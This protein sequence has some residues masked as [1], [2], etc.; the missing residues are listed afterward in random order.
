MSAKTA[1]AR[2]WIGSSSIA[3]ILTLSP[4]STPLQEY[5]K[6]VGEAPELVAADDEF[7]RRRKALEPYVREVVEQRTRIRITE[8]NIRYEDPASP[9]LRAEIDF[10][11]ID[12]EDGSEV[13]GEIKTVHP[14]AARE[15]GESGSDAY[16]IHVAAQV[17][18]G[19]M[20]RPKPRAVLIACVG[21]DDFRRY[22]ALPDPEIAARLR[23]DAVSFWADHVVPRVPP[24]PVSVEDMRRRYVVSKAKPV[25]ATDEVFGMLEQH[26][27]ACGEASRAETQAEALKLEIQKFIADHDT[28]MHHGRV[29]ATWKSSKDGTVTD[30][31]A[32]SAEASEILNSEQWGALLRKHTR[33]RPGNRPFLNKLK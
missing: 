20:I 9:F 4:L 30:W 31:K 3:G 5:Q 27:L 19:M 1:A 23:A 10:E 2:P 18:F 15:W 12:L 7:F 13:N 26:A 22:D 33:T 6:M 17:Q 8:Q 25:D 21:F 24:A 11:G 32:L 16:P 28:L 29:V 14:F